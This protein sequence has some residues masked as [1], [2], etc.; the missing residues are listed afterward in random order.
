MWPL[1]ERRQ[2]GLPTFHS[3]NWL[4]VDLR[5]CQTQIS[6]KL[7]LGTVCQS[8]RTPPKTAINICQ[9]RQ[10]LYTHGLHEAWQGQKEF[11]LHYTAQ[12]NCAI[13]RGI[14]SLGNL[15]LSTHFPEFLRYSVDIETHCLGL[16]PLGPRRRECLDP[17]PR[18]HQDPWYPLEF[19]NT[20]NLKE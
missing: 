1:K 19:Y 20:K 3:F 7:K 9:S 17:S 2:C 18:R 14:P 10:N 4:S 15:F 16:I 12:W 5:K 13:Q 8:A 11:S 6:D